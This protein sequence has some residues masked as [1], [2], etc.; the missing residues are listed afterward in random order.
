MGHRG[1]VLKD[2]LWAATSAYTEGEFIAHMD[3][4]KR[5]NNDS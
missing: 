4:L 1:V 5:M 2:K 3:E